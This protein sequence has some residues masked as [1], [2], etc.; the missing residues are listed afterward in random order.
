MSDATTKSYIQSLLDSTK[1]LEEQIKTLTATNKSLIERITKYDD[2]SGWGDRHKVWRYDQIAPKVS[3]MGGWANFRYFILNRDKHEAPEKLRLEQIVMKYQEALKVVLNEIA[4]PLE[5][6]KALV[7][8]Q[9][10]KLINEV[11]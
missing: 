6:R 5:Y 2:D 4:G 11:A 8:E 1:D 3:Q 9:I 10:S 7:K